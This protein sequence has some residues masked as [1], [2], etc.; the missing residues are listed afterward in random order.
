MTDRELP[1][2]DIIHTYPKNDL[3]E[4][5]TTG[6]PC[7]CNPEIR[8]DGYHIIHNSMDGREDYETGKR[9]MS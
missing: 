7:W 9:K 3:R 6:N 8:D 1:I 2:G 5:E 4:H